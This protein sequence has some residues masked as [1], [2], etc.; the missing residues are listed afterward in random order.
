MKFLAGMR[1]KFFV[2]GE[3]KSLQGSNTKQTIS[4]GVEMA[5]QMQK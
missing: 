3:K 5:S 4:C 2:I 1:W